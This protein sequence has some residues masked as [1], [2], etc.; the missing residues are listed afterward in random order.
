MEGIETGCEPAD[1]EAL[2]DAIVGQ[3]P[4]DRSIAERAAGNQAGT[5]E[6]LDDQRYYA[7]GQMGGTAR[8]VHR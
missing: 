1:G 2:P 6:T 5:C 7:H 3:S 4:D 8:Q